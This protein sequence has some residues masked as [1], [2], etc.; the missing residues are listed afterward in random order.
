MIISI[1]TPKAAGTSTLKVLQNTFGANAV[2]CDYQDD[3]S[4]PKST[5]YTNETNWLNSRPRSIPSNIAVIHGHFRPL[6]YQYYLDEFWFTFLRHPINNIISI[7]NYWLAIPE[8]PHSLHRKFKTRPGGIGVV[9]KIET[10]RYLYTK[11]YFG[12]WDMNSIDF[13]GSHE[14][15]SSDLKRLGVILNV[16]FDLITYENRTT[17]TNVTKDNACTPK[18]H[19]I[20]SAI[21]ADD[22]KFYERNALS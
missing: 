21:L 14:R 10:F 2:L 17:S 9:A 5:Q 15:R 6:K 22:I 12:G 19:S 3:P 4:D 13:V 18:T 1:H 16:S 11:T 20:L 7:Y 8:Q